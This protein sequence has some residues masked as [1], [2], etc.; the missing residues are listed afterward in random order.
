MLKALEDAYLIRSDT[1]RGTKWY[2]LTHDR[3]IGPI[4]ENNASWR[5][6]QLNPVQR[7]AAEWDAQHRPDGLLVTGDILADAEQWAASAD[8]ITGPEQEFLRA[9]REAED[10]AKEDLEHSTAEAKRARRR[11]MLFAGLAVV[12]LA[13]MITAAV[14][15]VIANSSRRDA[16]KARNAADA[17]ALK[18]QRSEDRARATQ[19]EAEARDLAARS[20]AAED[21]YNA[22]LLALEAESWTPSPL[23]QARSA[24]KDASA[25]L[26]RQPVQLQKIIAIG[27]PFIS[28]LAWSPDGNVI[29]VDDG[30]DSVR[31]FDAITGTAVG[32]PI[33][34]A[35]GLSQMAWNPIGTMI[36]TGSSEDGKLRLFDARTG[37]AVGDPISINGGLMSMAWNPAGTVVATGSEN[38]ML[39]LF[40]A[41]TG[42]AIGD[43]I[44]TGGGYSSVAWDSTGTV[45]ATVNSDG[46]L[47]RFNAATMAM[48][49]QPVSTGSGVSSVA[50]NPAGTA[51]ATVNN[52]GSLHLF[53]ATTGAPIGAPIG[54]NANSIAGGLSSAK[55][56][57]N[58]TAIAARGRDN[59]FRL[60]DVSSGTVGD[61]IPIAGDFASVEW[62]PAGTVL[63]TVDN[64]D[65]SLRLVDARSGSFLG[66]SIFAGGGGVPSV[67]WNPS[68]T[69]IAAGSEDG[70]LRLFGIPK[71][72]KVN[73]VV[74]GP[75][76]SFRR[77]H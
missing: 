35:G 54:N 59:I 42:D 18:A 43:S 17:A 76:A 9:A 30:F 4:V 75:R 27:A 68:G 28:A 36:A 3:M 33:S 61:P 40:D 20:E 16:Q 71:V 58:G 48:I 12:A 65:G 64:T 57:P 53:N 14:M 21:P 24:W 47:Q 63:A 70:Q 72:Q 67:A 50:W 38:G 5:E 49:G 73:Q 62:N 34:T 10:R 2:E 11:S 39:R 56:N 29:A 44:S 74:A 55:W 77:W 32:D 37:T 23:T 15:F 26:G 52:D 51:V 13:G 22:V 69:V 60:F 41:R 46:S 25:R 1:R 6:A 31:L 19:T 7:R 8:E 45:I 66:D